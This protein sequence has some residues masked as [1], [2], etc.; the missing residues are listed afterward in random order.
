MDT[1]T[2][3]PKRNEKMIRSVD[4]LKELY[5]VAVGVALV[6][7]VETLAKEDA[8]APV[9]G[10][11]SFFLFLVVV[12]TL[13]PFYHGA[14]R[15]MDDI[16]IFPEAPRKRP[17]PRV[18]LVDYL[19]LMFEAGLLVWLATSISNLVI[20]TQGFVFLMAV[21][22]LWAAVTGILT[23]AK[24]VFKWGILN[25][26]VGVTLFAV[27]YW[28]GHSPIQAPALCAIAIVR[29]ALDYWLS[30]RLYFPED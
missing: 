13:I 28:P 24:S 19:L 7:A 5:T 3:E 15:H 9:F 30:R 20:F 17:G 4:T 11:D 16:Y 14:F 10:R 23:P 6:M 29:S 25:F 27:S 12:V 8:T 26:I 21:D 22:V 18:L 1:R 2:G